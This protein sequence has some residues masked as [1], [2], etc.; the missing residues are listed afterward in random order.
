MM[1][2]VLVQCKA[3][4]ESA[5]DDIDPE[6]FIAFIRHIP[7][8]HETKAEIVHGKLFIT[9]T[10]TERRGYE[11]QPTKRGFSLRTWR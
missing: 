8:K 2:D 1:D 4:W 6:K 11:I 10:W 9:F 5:P 7:T 3:I